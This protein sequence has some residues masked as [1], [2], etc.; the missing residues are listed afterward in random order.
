VSN[1]LVAIPLLIEWVLVVTI[2]TPFA[3]V[4]NRFV[5]AHP[6]FGLTLWFTAFTTSALALLTALGLAV[7]SIF[8]TYATLQNVSG[9][10]DFW[11]SIA[12]SFAPW[13]LLAFGG[14]SLALITQ[15]LEPL[16]SLDATAP[17]SITGGSTLRMHRGVRVVVVELAVVLAFSL[18]RSITSTDAQIVVTRQTIAQLTEAEGG[19]IEAT[20]NGFLGFE[21]N[22]GQVLLVSGK[23]VQGKFLG[24]LNDAVA[25]AVG[26]H[27][28]H[29]Q[30]RLKGALGHPAGGEAIDL[31]ALSYAAD[32][33]AMGNF[34]QQG[35]LGFGVEGGVKGHGGK[36]AKN[37]IHPRNAS[38]TH[39]LA[40]C[41]P[42]TPA[43]SIPSP[44][45]TST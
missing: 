3:L 17:T 30:W 34:A 4:N 13:L 28:H 7:W 19:C 26:P 44:W 21:E 10:A 12:S 14:I 43:A 24:A 18:G 45:A 5:Y 25:G 6:R 11:P 39:R 33:H 37:Y 29:H 40:R 38:G 2:A 32:E 1:L 22:C 9:A 27:S 41:A 8:D 42:S 20:A 15:R 23:H 35:F 16:G 36:S 31:I